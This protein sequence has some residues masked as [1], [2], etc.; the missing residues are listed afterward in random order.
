MTRHP[1]ARRVERPAD[2]RRSGRR[3]ARAAR[4]ATRPGSPL[5]QFTCRL[6]AILAWVVA[7]WPVSRAA[8]DDSLARYVPADAG[9]YVEVRG[10]T[11]LLIPLTDSTLWMTLAELAGQPARPEEIEGWRR[12]IRDSIGMTPEQA[13]REL[14]A[15]GVAYFGEGLGRAQDAVLVCRRGEGKPLKE[16]IEQWQARPIPN[17]GRASVYQLKSDVGLG[18]FDDL[19]VFGD[20]TRPGGQFAQVLRL[21]EPRPPASLADAPAFQGLLKR[22][23]PKPDAVLYARIRAEAAAASQP[24]TASAPA[25]QPP[26]RPARLDLPGPLRGAS[27]MLLALHRED[28]RLHFTAVGDAPAAGAARSSRV[29]ELA[30]RLPERTLL[31][32][33]TELDYPALVEA[34]RGLPERHIV[35][36]ALRLQER[37]ATVPRL[38]EALDPA[39]CLA[40][41]MVEPAERALPAPPAPA[42]ALLLAARDA[43]AAE[44][45]LNALMASSVSVY[46][47][48]SLTWGLPALT[49]ATDRSVADTPVH[50]VDLSGLLENF[51]K[52]LSE[53][54]LCWARDGDVLI[55]ASHLDWLEQILESRHGQ[56]ATLEPVLKLARRAPGAAASTVL[57]VQSGPISDLGSLW[58]RYLENVAPQVLREEWWRDRQPAS[59]NARLGINVEQPEG[60][61]RLRV[62]SV[63]DDGPAAGVLRPGDVLVGTAGQRFATTQPVVEIRRALTERPNARWIDLQVERGGNIRNCRVALPFVDPVQVLRRVIAI[64]KLAQ[65]VV[66]YEDGSAAEGPR[67]ALTVELRTSQAPLFDLPT[68]VPIPTGSQRE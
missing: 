20:A 14:F 5:N 9:L 65:R 67:G 44:Q 22:V 2:R 46:N 62:T 32:W 30:P 43:D 34:A 60:G 64:G 19:L 11:D 66:Y 27:R 33:A 53:L 7:A 57:A 45:E 52:G 50:F 10:A 41:G 8:A 38:I 55:I 59:R 12:Q 40:V 47:L 17:A 25:S 31:A 3:A 56:S 28:S 1:A 42:A 37:S 29:V 16:L 63:D 51:D 23:P 58:L 26:R 15:G 21:A 49:Q 13:I 4:D 35:R 36:L 61:T 68:A 54:H 18:A 24:A 48:L 39:V 6:A